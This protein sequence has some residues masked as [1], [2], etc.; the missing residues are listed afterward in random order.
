MLNPIFIMKICVLDAND[1]RQFKKMMCLT[2]I[3]YK[4]PLDIDHF[5]IFSTEIIQDLRLIPIEDC[6]GKKVLL[7]FCS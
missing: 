1:T 2:D 4:K 7:K 5:R 3:Y 6:V